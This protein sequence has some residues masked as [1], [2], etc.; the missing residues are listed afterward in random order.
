MSELH[1]LDIICA[2]AKVPKK[3]I[4]KQRLVLRQ[5]IRKCT[6]NLKI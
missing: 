4:L 5:L 1:I 3:Q 2:V 6:W